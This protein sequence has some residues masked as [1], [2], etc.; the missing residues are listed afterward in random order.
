[1]KRRGVWLVGLALA[2][3]VLGVAVQVRYDRRSIRDVFHM[4][5]TFST[6]DNGLSLAYEYLR[7]RAA[8]AGQDPDQA[9]AALHRRVEPGSLPER[10]VVFRFRPDLKP[11]LLSEEEGEEEGEEE[12]EDNKDGKDSKDTKDGEKDEDK[13]NQDDEVERALPLLSDPEEA[14]VRGGGRLV[15]ALSES[16]GPLWLDPIQGEATVQKVFPLWP[17]VAKLAPT[18]PYGLAGPPLAAGHAVFLVGESPVVVR[19]PMGSGD[20]IVLSTPE[21]LENKRLGEADH[22]ALLEALTEKRPVRFDERSHLLGDTAGVFETLGG[23]GFGPFLLLAG[24][25]AGLAIWRAAVRTGPPERDDRDTR[26]DAVE[27]VDSLADLYD[28]ALRRGDAVRL[29]HESFVHAVAADTGLRGTALEAR[30]QD[31]LERA[32]GWEPLPPPEL[33]RERDLPRDRFDRML[34]TL[35]EAFRRLQDAK[36]K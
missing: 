14:W 17:G 32:G 22:L 25:T 7:A 13:K 34:R 12:E 33:S 1:V 24:L 21:I 20:V 10:G 2:L 23:W 15:L 18:E 28:R 8:R 29:Y 26:S 36:R 19:I 16:Y 6:D 11:F 31:L 27:L 4:G 9:V 5:S 3:Y 35:N 30:A